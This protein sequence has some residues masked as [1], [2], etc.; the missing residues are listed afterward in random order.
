MAALRGIAV[1]L[2]WRMKGAEARPSLRQVSRERVGIELEGM[3]RVRT[4]AR[5]PPLRQEEIKAMVAWSCVQCEQ[6]LATLSACPHR[7]L[8]R[9]AQGADPCGALRTLVRVGLAPAVFEARCPPLLRHIDS[10]SPPP[11]AV[12]LRGR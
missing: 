4:E 3:L 5:P 9:P 1:H 2:T 6:L 10:T 11:A 12:L 8:L 7:P